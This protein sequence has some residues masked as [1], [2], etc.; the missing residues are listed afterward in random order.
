MRWDN[1]RCHGSQL[2]LVIQAYRGIGISECDESNEWRHVCNE[3]APKSV[4]AGRASLP[5]QDPE[6]HTKGC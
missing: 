2:V 6:D 1:E 5:S 3:S 4:G